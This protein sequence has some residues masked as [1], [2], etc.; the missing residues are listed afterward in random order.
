MLV[1]WLVHRESRT[2]NSGAGPGV[3]S[4]KNFCHLLSNVI[5]SACRTT[6]YVSNASHRPL[7]HC[8]FLQYPCISPVGVNP[9]RFKYLIS[10]KLSEVHCGIFLKAFVGRRCTWYIAYLYLWA[11]DREVLKGSLCDKHREA[12]HRPWC[13]RDLQEFWIENSRFV[14]GQIL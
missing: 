4:E 7:F 6:S 11:G 2:V 12:H 14:N 1:Y 8:I 5:Y 9:W 13:E 10:V 3:P